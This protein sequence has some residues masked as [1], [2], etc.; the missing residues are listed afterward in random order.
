MIIVGA[1]SYASGFC[2]PLKVQCSSSPQLQASG[3]HEGSKV[4]MDGSALLRIVIVT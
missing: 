2:Y 3:A 1:R 4:D